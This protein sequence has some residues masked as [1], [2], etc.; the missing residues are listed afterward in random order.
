MSIEFNFHSSIASHHFNVEP[1]LFGH[2]PNALYCHRKRGRLHQCRSGA[3]F[4]FFFFYLLTKWSRPFPE[5]IHNQGFF[6]QGFAPVLLVKE[7]VKLMGGE[8][9]LCEYPNAAPQ[10]FTYVCFKKQTLLFKITYIFSLAL[11]M[12]IITDNMYKNALDRWN[13]VLKSTQKHVNP[14]TQILLLDFDAYSKDM[15]IQNS[16][17]YIHIDSL[18][19]YASN[20]IS[21][22]ETHP[23]IC[24]K[25]LDLCV[26]TSV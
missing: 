21:D 17:Y 9:S 16:L 1:I 12:E 10:H 11:Q 19:D 6:A 4:F 8:R 18:P 3:F 13:K 7:S 25:H 14:R 24:I 15:N 22:F 2:R 20:R 5:K 23:P 26:L